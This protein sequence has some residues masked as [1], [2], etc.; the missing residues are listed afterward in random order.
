MY[1]Q[2]EVKVNKTRGQICSQLDYIVIET[3]RARNLILRAMKEQM[4]GMTFQQNKL[5]K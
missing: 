5:M 4:L 3:Q 1:Y 2:A